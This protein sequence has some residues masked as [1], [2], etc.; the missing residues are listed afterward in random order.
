MLGNACNVCNVGQK[1]QMVGDG[2]PK[3]VTGKNHNFYCNINTNAMD[4]YL[5]NS[6]ITHIHK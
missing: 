6:K 4:K 1:T 2:D 3:T 5:L